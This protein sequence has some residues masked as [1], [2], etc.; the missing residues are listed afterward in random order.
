MARRLDHEENFAEAVKK[1][2][3]AYKKTEVG[4][5]MQALIE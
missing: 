3:R 4:A 2:Y 1:A 5:E